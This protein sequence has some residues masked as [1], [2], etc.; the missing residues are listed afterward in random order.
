MDKHIGFNIAPHDDPTIAAY[1]IATPSAGLGEYSSAINTSTRITL[2]IEPYVG[3]TQFLLEWHVDDD[4]MTPDH[5]LNALQGIR[6]VAE[7]L[8]IERDY[9]IGNMKIVI[10]DGFHADQQARSVR[11]ATMQAF[12]A[13]LNVATFIEVPRLASNA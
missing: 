4:H 9:P 13:A 3:D 8:K 2:L 7:T 12:E 10:T 1:T 5:V 11:L 6:Q